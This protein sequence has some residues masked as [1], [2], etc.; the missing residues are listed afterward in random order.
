M[1]L[2]F[3][4][5]LGLLE[6]KAPGILSVAYYAL[7]L[8]SLRGCSWLGGWAGRFYWGAFGLVCA[9]MALVAALVGLTHQHEADGFNPDRLMV[10]VLATIFGVYVCASWAGCALAQRLGRVGEAWIQFLCP[11]LLV[12]SIVGEVGPLGIVAFAGQG[13][14]A[15]FL[16]FR[17]L[18]QQSVEE[19]HPGLNP[20]A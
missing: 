17:A 14:H 5:G 13:L 8:W 15:L 7:L 4:C 18:P 16:A 12:L 19:G 2:A 20:S 6:A 10:G 9:H 1:P 3:L 11:G